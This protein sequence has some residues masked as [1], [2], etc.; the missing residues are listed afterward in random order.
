MA[1]SIEL[2]RLRTLEYSRFLTEDVPETGTSIGEDVGD[3]FAQSLSS[4]DATLAG[5]HPPWKRNLHALLEHPRSSPSAFLL[6]MTMLF[7]ILFSA[8]VTVMETVPAFHAISTRA[9]F[10]VETSLVAIFTVEYIARCFAWSGTWFSLLK[11][12]TCGWFSIFLKK[13]N[14]SRV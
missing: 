9:W 6:H 7:L 8:L 2:T 5:I 1:P 13:K 10:G 3:I 11:W 14:S 4:D 12:Q